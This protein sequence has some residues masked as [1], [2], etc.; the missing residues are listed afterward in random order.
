MSNGNPAMYRCFVCGM[1][2]RPSDSTVSRLALCWLK[3]NTK[4]VERVSE[5]MYTYRHNF[6]KPEDANIDIQLPLF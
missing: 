6:C 2:L 1:G 3:S 4:T 5:E